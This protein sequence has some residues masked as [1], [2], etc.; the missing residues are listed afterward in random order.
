MIENIKSQMRKGLLEYCILVVIS[1]KEA[2]ASDLLEILRKADLF[3]V[4]GTV[5]PLL[6]RMK[7]SGLLD[8]RWQESPDGPPR[9]YFR[10][11]PAGRELQQQ[12]D[13]EWAAISTSINA[14]I[15]SEPTEEANTPYTEDDPLFRT[16]KE[17]IK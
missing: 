9:K 14:I 3:V 13:Q 4:E 12:L 10:L 8:Y 16:Q 6:S 1:R 11:T 5:Y 15:A 7:N 2:Y 17:T